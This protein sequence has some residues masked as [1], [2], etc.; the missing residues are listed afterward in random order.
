MPK[1]QRILKYPQ[2]KEE[3]IRFVKRH[4]YSRRCP[5]VWSVAICLK[6]EKGKIQAVLMY[7]PSPYPTVERAFVR[8]PTHIKHHIWQSRMVG[9]GITSAELDSLIERANNYLYENNYWWVHTL[10]QYTE[11]RIDS[12]MRLVCKG[13][14]GHVY[15]RTGASYLGLAGRK[16]LQGF[17][18]DG[19]AIHKR[20]GAV[21]L[22]KANIRD[23]Y[24]DAKSIRA[25][26]GGKKQRWVYILAKTDAEYQYRRTWMAYTIQEY[27]VLRQPLLLIQLITLMYLILEE[28]EGDLKAARLAPST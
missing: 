16:A 10:T 8:D 26:W 21:T 6:N 17:L 19:R 18:I 24:P 1:T 27:Q 23:Y 12:A 9:A 2:N 25:I 22:S 15:Q 5:A 28:T 4:H 11:S 3:I 14:T 13:F 20:Q 7:G